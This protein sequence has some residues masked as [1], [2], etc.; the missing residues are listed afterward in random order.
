MQTIDPEVWEKEY[1]EIFFGDPRMVEIKASAKKRIAAAKK[2]EEGGLNI[3]PVEKKPVGDLTQ[4]FGRAGGAGARSNTK[5]SKD[6]A[7]PAFT[8]G[9]DDSGDLSVTTNSEG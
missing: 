5:G 9:A 3:K 6:K 8:I 2:G 1:Q 4:F 7:P